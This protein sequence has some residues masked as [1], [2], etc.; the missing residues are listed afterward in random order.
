MSPAGLLGPVRW[1]AFVAL[2]LM[3]QFGGRAAC[4]AQ[5]LPSFELRNWDGSAVSNA[6]LE[7]VVTIVAFTYAKCIFA[8]PMVTFQL[9]ELDL[10]LEEPPDVRY[11]HVSVNPADDTAE[12]V[13]LHFSKHEIDPHRDSRWMFLNGPEDSLSLFWPISVS[14]CRRRGSRA[15]I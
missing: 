14:R 4:S 10:E 7:G 3:L 5:E 1:A 11:L 12:E 9:R 8:C 13:L 6:S 2:A 15:A